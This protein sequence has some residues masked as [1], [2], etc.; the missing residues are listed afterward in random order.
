MTTE[1]LFRKS[2]KLWGLPSQILMLVEELNELS[3]ASLHLLRNNKPK[4][5]SREK[6]AEEI[7]DVEFMLEEMKHYFDNSGLITFY[8]QR[9]EARLR[10]LIKI[11]EEKEN[12]GQ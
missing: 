1:E 12:H 6:F 7:A 2:R 5:E 8:K 11:E 9:K 10:E 3:V 4:K